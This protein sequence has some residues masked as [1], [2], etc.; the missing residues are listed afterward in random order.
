MIV[1]W[2]LAGCGAWLVG[3]AIVGIVQGVWRGTREAFRI[4]R[5]YRRMKRMSLDELRDYSKRNL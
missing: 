1:V 4:R 2:I 3:S 5:S